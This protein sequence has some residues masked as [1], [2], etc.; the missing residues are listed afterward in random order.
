MPFGIPIRKLSPEN[1][2]TQ[3]PKCNQWRRNTCSLTK[4]RLHGQDDD[5][6]TR[7]CTCFR[8]TLT[9]LLAIY[10]TWRFQRAATDSFSNNYGY[11]A[12][13]S[14]KLI[15]ES[16]NNRGKNISEEWWIQISKFRLKFCL[17]YSVSINFRCVFYL[18]TVINPL[19]CKMEIEK[20][21]QL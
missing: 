5:N 18:F 15:K 1:L 12:I 2:M 6:E 10:C 8:I 20:H 3:Q 19:V 14:V 16:Q 4:P 11:L 7:W 13:A 21:A 17:K 9:W